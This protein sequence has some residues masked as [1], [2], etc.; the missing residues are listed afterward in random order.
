MG[1]QIEGERDAD[2]GHGG[3]AGTG[4]PGI[5]SETSPLLHQFGGE[6]IAARFPGNQKGMD[7][8]HGMSLPKARGEFTPEEQKGRHR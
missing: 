7:L 1:G 6:L 2:G 4:E 3:T 5:R 8:R